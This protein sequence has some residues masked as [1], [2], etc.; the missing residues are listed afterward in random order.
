MTLDTKD[1]TAKVSD[2]TKAIVSFLRLLGIPET[3][4]SG[5]SK[6]KHALSC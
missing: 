5:C 3:R 2:I 6:V 4:P 1:T